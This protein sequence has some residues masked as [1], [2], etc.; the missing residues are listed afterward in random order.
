MLRIVLVGG[1]FFASLPFMI[2]LQ[3]LLGRIA[4]KDAV[5]VPKNGRVTLDL[6][7]EQGRSRDDVIFNQTERVYP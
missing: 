3:W 1:F 6:S 5:T 2:A 4:I 7:V